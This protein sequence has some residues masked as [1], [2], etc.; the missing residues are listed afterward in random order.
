MDKKILLLVIVVALAVAIVPSVFSNENVVDAT[1][2]DDEVIEIEVRSA[3][4]R[5]LPAEIRV[6]VGATVRITY[7]NGGGRHDWVLDE[8]DAATAI[9]GARQSE[10]VE[11]V[12][13][14]AGEFEFYCSVPGHRQGGMFGQFIVVE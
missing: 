6:N 10:T 4:L 13:D 3:G 1:D 5:Y 12:A 9:I 8:F 7:V 11:F 14:K 2:W